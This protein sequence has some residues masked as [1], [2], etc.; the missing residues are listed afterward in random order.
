MSVNVSIGNA[1]RRSAKGFIVVDFRGFGFKTRHTLPTK[2]VAE[3][4]QQVRSI[5]NR[6]AEL[7]KDETHKFYS[8]NEKEQKAFIFGGVE[9]KRQTSEITN[10]EED[11]ATVFL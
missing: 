6:C 7:Q 8:W 4:K 10:L 1:K 9:P 11:R 3:A 2:V 5:E